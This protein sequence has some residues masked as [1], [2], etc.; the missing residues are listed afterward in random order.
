MPSTPSQ[1]SIDVCRSAPTSVTWWTPW[2]W[3]LRIAP[4]YAQRLACRQPGATGG[5]TMGRRMIWVAVLATAATAF[6]FTTADATRTVRIASRITIESHGLN[7][8]GKVKSENSGCKD[9]RHVSLY[10]K[11]SD[12][13]RQRVGVFV[14]GPS[15]K[16]HITVS[17]SAGITMSRFYAKVRQ[18]KEG[19]AGT[20]FVCKSADS[21]VTR[22]EEYPRVAPRVATEADLES[23]TNTLTLAFEH[24]PLW[25]WA[26]P[27][28]GTLEPFWRMF[29]GS[30]LRYRQ[31]WVV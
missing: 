3:S 10:R 24:D 29:I 31:V 18:R 8:H 27:E 22:V 6:T 9:A 7:F 14:T 30:A 28:P 11:F 2:L 16:W 19:T 5:G 23:L 15:G 17:G 1:K 25:R 12:G 20:I 21:E 13:S 26:F 4:C